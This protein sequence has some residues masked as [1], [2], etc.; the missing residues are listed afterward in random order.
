MSVP[1]G[2][3]PATAAR[4]KT[5]LHDSRTQPRRIFPVAESAEPLVEDTAEIRSLPVCR[6]RGLELGKTGCQTCGGIRNLP[7]YQ[8][9]KFGK[10]TSL[11]RSVREDVAFCG[12][13]SQLAPVWYTR[14]VQDL[15]NDLIDWSERLPELSGVCGIPRSGV[16]AAS[17]LSLIR[18]IPLISYDA[19]RASQQSHRRPDGRQLRSVVSAPVLVVDD[20]SWTG[21]AM[22]RTRNELA[23]V[24][25]LLFGAVYAGP[26]GRRKCDVWGVEIDN[27]YHCF[28]WN[29][30]R[31]VHSQTTMLDLDG[32]ISPDPPPPYDFP[33]ESQTP[34]ANYLEFL[35][36]AVPQRWPGFKVDTICTARLERFR[37]ETEAWLSKHGIEY[38]RLIMHP[39]ATWQE[40][41]RQGHAAFKAEHYAASRCTLFVESRP[42]QARRI[43]QLTQRPVISTK[44][45]HV[46]Q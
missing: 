20:T 9:D 41:E 42:E 34:A 19:L 32:V 44:P 31:D 6:H 10:C 38:S 45:W 8:C 3:S 1:I 11:R 39:A 7:L 18:N 4:L 16:P 29:V 21:S 27:W 43:Y 13:C 26:R 33:D 23:N 12:D 14:S 22:R 30:G 35:H 24:P 15:Q 5:M 36:T 28:E 46:F 40:R 25:D 37:P 17:L 2:T